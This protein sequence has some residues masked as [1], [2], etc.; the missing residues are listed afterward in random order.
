MTE[1]TEEKR[2]PAQAEPEQAAALQPEQKPKRQA[3]RKT[4]QKAEPQV[5]TGGGSVVTGNVDTGG[6]TFIGRDQVVI[7]ILSTVVGAAEVKDLENL[8]PEPGDPPFQGLQYFDE[9]DAD[10]FFGRELLIARIVARLGRTRFLA[11]IGASGSGKSSVVRAG[12]IPA[13]RR[14]QRLADGG[15]PPTDSGQWAIHTFTPTAH[16]LE[17]LAAVLTQEVESLSALSTLRDELAD[18]AGTLPLAA[19]RYLAQN[20]RKHLLLF[21]DQF[22]EVFTLCRRPEER[23][24]FLANLLAA[25]AEGEDTPVTVLIALRADYYAQVAQHDRLREIVSQYQEFIGAMSRDELVRAIDRPLAMGKWQ[26]QEGLI[27]V[28]LDD[29]GYEPGALPLLSHALHE[30][31]LR[32]RGRTLTLSGYT[33]AGGVRGAVAKTAESVFQQ[34]PEEQ[35][36]VARMIFLRMAEVGEDSHDT[37]RRATYSELITRATDELLIEAVIKILADARLVTTD[38]LQPGGTKVVEVAHEALIR[39]WPTLRS[40]LEEDRAGLILHQHLT[41]DTNE[42]IKAGGDPGLLYRGSRLQQASTWAEGNP[43]ALSLQEQ[44]FLE[45]SRRQAQEE[46]E[47]ARRLARASRL[48]RIFIGVTALLLVA[49]AYLAYNFFFRQDPVFMNGFFNIA[50]ADAAEHTEEGSPSPTLDSSDQAVA[51][52]IYNGL[53]EELGQNPNI[54]IWHDGPELR[55]L[56]VT[57][58]PVGGGTP[59][60]Q[61]Q[62]AAQIAERLQANMV[63]YPASD[64]S[65]LQLAF[66]LA[67]R[68]DYNYEDLQGGFQLDCSNS[69]AGQAL[70]EALGP[71]ANAL[72]E[73]AVGLTEVQLGHSLEAL[74]AFL[75]ANEAF[76]ASA[77]IQFLIGREYLFLVERE[78]VL[79]FAS[80]LFET[81]AEKAFTESAQLDPNYPR[82]YIGLGSVYFKRAQRQ[83]EIAK[84]KAESGEQNP[85][86]LTQALQLIDQAISAYDKALSLGTSYP[87]AGIPLASVARLGL[88]NSYRLRGEALTRQ[89]DTAGAMEQYDQAIAALDPTLQ[90]LEEANQIRYLTQ[91]FEYLGSTYEWKAYT[92]IVDQDYA[93]GQADYQRALEY[94]ERCIAQADAT[95]DLIVKNDIVGRVCQPGKESIQKR[96]QSLEGTQG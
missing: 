55:D 33:E 90:P 11:I 49:I 17:A 75:N 62:S 30:T 21:V 92:R 9:K 65:R 29:I 76:P 58:G 63:I 91:A 64:P 39:E 8:P 53:N 31:W 67:P 80:D 36:P 25:S 41:D 72:G 74:E 79:E 93:G 96:L 24:A 86:E 42:W 88:G 18:D 32:R 83:L 54:L 71:C 68:P 51:E 56:N 23:E 13:L 7:N 4:R 50:V 82:A 70:Q 46:A 12:V 81:E 94:F 14:G 61:L 28:I 73:I 27:E 40:W 16:P 1:P 69:T 85:G 87:E 47:Q 84:D 43:D 26:I 59:E 89:G 77:L 44:D 60:A 34:L 19:R 3:Q 6:G 57:I 52:I 20:Q 5:N 35:Q 45:A 37:R 10:R 48:Q 78:K 66:Y 22:E 38:T 15:L 2:S 95:Q